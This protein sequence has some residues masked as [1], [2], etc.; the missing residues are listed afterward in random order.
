MKLAMAQFR[1]NQIKAKDLAKIPDYLLPVLWIN[2][3]NSI[4]NKH[5][6]PLYACAE[7]SCICR[8]CP[9]PHS[10]GNPAYFFNLFETIQVMIVKTSRY[11]QHAQNWVLPVSVLLSQERQHWLIKKYFLYLCA[12]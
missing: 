7:R 12:V 5:S 8:E 10:P 1:C 2:L 9:K 6:V 4:I 3:I 11:V